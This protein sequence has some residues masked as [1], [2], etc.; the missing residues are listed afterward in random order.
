MAASATWQQSPSRTLP[1][2]QTTVVSTPQ[3]L[4]PRITPSPAC[5]EP[6]DVAIE[7]STAILVTDYTRFY[8]TPISTF[9]PV[10][11]ALP[12]GSL[13]TVPFMDDL[14]RSYLSLL[15]TAMLAT[16][17]LRNIIVCFDYLRRVNLKRKTLFYLLLCSQLLSVGY[18]L[19]P[20]LA[21]VQFISDRSGAI[22]C[23]LLQFTP[24]L[25]GVCNTA[26]I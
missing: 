1:P 6:N 10:Y 19:E 21:S 25:H 26:F 20:P 14:A 18:F 5:Y 12:D 3:L 15:V 13:T 7:L 24:R 16:L 17:F 23:L 4:A 11:L 8:D 9:Q 22:T 2:R